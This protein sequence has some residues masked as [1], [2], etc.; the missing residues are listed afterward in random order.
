MGIALRVL[1]RVRLEA[2]EDEAHEGHVGL[3]RVHVDVGVPELAL[4]V[5]EDFVARDGDGAVR[6]LIEDEAAGFAVVGGVLEVL[7]AGVVRETRVRSPEGVE[8]PLGEEGKELVVGAQRRP[9][10]ALVA[11]D[12]AQPLPHSRGEPGPVH[13]HAEPAAGAIAGELRGVAV[14]PEGREDVEEP[15]RRGTR[16]ARDIEQLLRALARDLEA[17]IVGDGLGEV[18]AEAGRRDAGVVDLAALGVAELVAS[19]RVLHRGGDHHGRDGRLED[20][21][22]VLGLDRELE[23]RGLR[24]LGAPLG[25]GEVV[26]VLVPAGGE[27]DLLRAPPA[28]GELIVDAGEGLAKAAVGPDLGDVGDD[29]RLLHR[30]DE[31]NRAGR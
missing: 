17:R 25:L 29:E 28:D 6:D 20:D 5:V 8:A 7:E 18:L 13:V 15:G 30:V 10:L 21:L 24:F 16:G 2:R 19:A 27:S 14:P 3:A 26:V 31:E 1:D 12:D 23:D 4:L 11:E 9:A 22:F